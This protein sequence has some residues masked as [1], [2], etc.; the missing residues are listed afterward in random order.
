MLLMKA[1]EADGA[2]LPRCRIARDGCRAILSNERI[3][4]DGDAVSQTEDSMGRSHIILSEDS[5]G[6]TCI[7]LFEDRAE[8]DHAILLEDSKGWTRIILL[9]DRAEQDRAIL[10]EDSAGRGRAMPSEDS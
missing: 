6:Q 4:R 7:I 3:M 5:K 2:R 9:K 8:R 1:S 10:S